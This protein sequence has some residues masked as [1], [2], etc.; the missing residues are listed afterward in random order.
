M[1]IS[2][3]HNSKKDKSFIIHTSAL[4]TLFEYDRSDF[5]LGREYALSFNLNGNVITLKGKSAHSTGYNLRVGV[6]NIPEK[7]Y[8]KYKNKR[9]FQLDLIEARKIEYK[10]DKI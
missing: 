10:H 1:L 8:K 3:I 5:D 9:K 6:N 4:R 2:A 7:L